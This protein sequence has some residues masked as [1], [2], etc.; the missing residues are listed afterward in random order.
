MVRDS[1]D[2][3]SDQNQ[4]REPA[5]EPQSPRQ[6]PEESHRPERAAEKINAENKD[7][8]GS[9]LDFLLWCKL[10]FEEESE[11]WRLPE[12]GADA[13][14]LPTHIRPFT[15]F[16]EYRLVKLTY[17]QLQ[18]SGFYW[19]PMTME[20][21]HQRLSHAALG[22]FL[23][24]DSGQPDV[25]FTLSYQSEDG[26]TSVRVQLNNLLFSL[27]GSQKTFPSLFALLAFYTSSPCRLT[28]P[29]RRQRPER[30]KQMCR[31]ALVRTYGAERMCTSPGLSPDVKAYVGAYPYCT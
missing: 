22:T 2:R 26:P 21:A 23:L 17:L 11:S 6:N 19:G 9:K 4:K 7:S 28:E 3:T 14:G 13:D 24:R 16:A 18:E 27:H 5:A 25:F 30:L 20:E 1:L 31:R 10:K 29:Y 12:T 15:S 8:A